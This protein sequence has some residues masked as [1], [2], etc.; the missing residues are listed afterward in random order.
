[1]AEVITAG[2][3]AAAETG[4][5]W[6]GGEAPRREVRRPGALGRQATIRHPERGRRAAWPLA[7]TLASLLLVGA[8]AGLGD[9]EQRTLTGG[10][11]GA[12]GGAILGAIG[13]NAALGAGAGGAAGLLGG[14][15]Y[16]QYQ[17]SRQEPR[18][19]Q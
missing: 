3:D 15:L 7:L 17:Q 16:D 1:M 18:Q 14:Y 12:T 19:P 2:L 13:G 5:G 11:A 8:C 4:T 9:T 6:A 10:A